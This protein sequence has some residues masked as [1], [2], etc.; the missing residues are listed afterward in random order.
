MLELTALAWIVVVLAA[1]LIGFGKTA[2]PGAVGLLV[3]PSVAAVMDPQV[4]VGFLLGVL[5]LADVMAAL[6]WRHHVEWGRLVRLLPAA[7]LGIITGYFCHKQIYQSDAQA[8]LMPGMGV[9]VLVLLG[10]TT[11]RNS[12][13]GQQAQISSG[14]PF[15]AAM[16]FLAGLTTILTN[17][18]GSIMV[19]YL[20]AMRFDTKKLLGTVA[21]YFFIMN[22]VKIP[23][24]MDVG[25]MDR[26]TVLT[27]LALLPVIIVGGLLGL[28]LAGRIPTKTFHRVISGLAALVSVVLICKGLILLGSD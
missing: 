16:G 22:L 20:I 21:W 14:L 25:V 2:M 26:K 9:L 15:A 28:A 3:V 4:S 5:C 27:N 24:L 19:I 8:L 7:M 23:F 18:A 1:L 10:V 6:V 11:W 13:R 12:R 17:A